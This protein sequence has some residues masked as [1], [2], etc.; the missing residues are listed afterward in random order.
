[1]KKINDFLE[2]F[3]EIN[4]EA[5]YP[6]DMKNAIIGY[7]ERIGIEPLILLDKQKCLK[8]LEEKGMSCEEVNEY[9]DYNIINSWIGEGTPYFATLIKG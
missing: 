7:V 2:M 3:K 9:F 1:M 6:T 4:P 5:F 8:I